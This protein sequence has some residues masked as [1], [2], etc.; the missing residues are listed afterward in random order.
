MMPQTVGVLHPALALDVQ[1]RQL[2]V[3]ALLHSSRL[4]LLVL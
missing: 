2:K 3:I 4:V 1:N